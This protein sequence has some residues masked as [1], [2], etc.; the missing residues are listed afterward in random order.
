MIESD[1]AMDFPPLPLSVLGLPRG[2]MGCL[3][4]P[5]PA[6]ARD[7]GSNTMPVSSARPEVI[8]GLIQGMSWAAERSLPRSREPVA[9]RDWVLKAGLAPE[10]SGPPGGHQLAVVGSRHKKAP[11]DAGALELLN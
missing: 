7:S 4:K 5:L 8:A 9:A 6:A 3:W 10:I 11:D 2:L 1:L